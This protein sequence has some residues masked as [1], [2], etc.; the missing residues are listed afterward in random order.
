MKLVLGGAGCCRREGLE[1][2][3]IVQCL[4]AG[5]V[6]V[7]D[8]GIPQ[9][10]L[11]AP[12]SQPVVFRQRRALH[13]REWLAVRIHP[14]AGR[15]ALCG[16]AGEWQKHARYPAAH[17]RGKAAAA[18][19]AA[20]VRYEYRAKH[21]GEAKKMLTVIVVHGVPQ[22]RSRES[23]LTSAH[24]MGLVGLLVCQLSVYIDKVP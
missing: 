5:R 21:N 10:Q 23:D 2:V 4:K 11:I 9:V 6:L 7:G 1:H 19:A 24:G 14:A 13:I 8:L 18:T 22:E 12:R 16:K 15:R 20:T 17:R 3:K